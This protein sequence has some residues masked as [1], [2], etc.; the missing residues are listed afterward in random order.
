MFRHQPLLK[1]KTVADYLRQAR[2]GD[3]RSIEIIAAKLK[4]RASYLAALEKGKYTEL[5][6]PVY[7]KNYLRL[8]TKELHLPWERIEPLYTQEIRVVGSSHAPTDRVLPR[9]TGTRVATRAR[10]QQRRASAAEVSA[11]HQEALLIPRILKLGLFGVVVLVIV[12]YFAWGVIR[13]V[14]PPE[15]T[16]VQPAQDVLVTK[17][18][19]TIEGQTVPEVSAAINGQ[20]VAVDPNGHFTEEVTLHPGLNTIQISVKSKLSRERVE[21]RNILYNDKQ[22]ENK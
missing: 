20:S 15:L 5:P 16:I 8:Y 10:A 14:T 2:E 21:I 9:S 3:G 7:V 19:I 22:E 4:I 18:T 12:L 17:S 11:H 13:L 1:Q 6:S